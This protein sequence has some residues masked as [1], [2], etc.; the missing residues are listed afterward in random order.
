MTNSSIQNIIKHTDLLKILANSKLRYKKAILQKAD[1]KFILSICDII[2]NLLQGNVNLSNKEKSELNKHKSFLRK[3]VKKSS[4]EEKKKIIVQKG[5]GVLSIILPA[6]LSTLA[7]L[8][9]EICKKIN[10]CAICKTI[11]K[12][13]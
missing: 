7:G 8:Y 9:N 3:F 1:K 10:G 4:I 5:S 12:S 6:V 13:R 2:F 11:G